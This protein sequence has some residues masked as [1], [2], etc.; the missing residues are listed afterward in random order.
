M[1]IAVNVLLMEKAN[2]EI[3]KK[4]ISH[5]YFRKIVFLFG[6]KRIGSLSKSFQI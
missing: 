2:E 6:K 1:I 5:K 4:Y 3:S